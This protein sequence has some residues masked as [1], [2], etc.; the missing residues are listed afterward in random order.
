MF[1]IVIFCYKNCVVI[2]TQL[3]FI[4]ICSNVIFEKYFVGVLFREK[5]NSLVFLCLGIYAL[6]Y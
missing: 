5:K 2:T 6:H 1:P 3:Y 4:V